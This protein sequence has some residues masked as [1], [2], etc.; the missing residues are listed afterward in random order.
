MALARGPRRLSKEA[1]YEQ[2]IALAMPVIAREGFGGFSLEEIA[3]QADVTRNNL[4]RYFP[5]GRPDIVAAV[6]KEAGRELTSGWVTDPELSLEQRLRANMALIADHA[7][8]PSDAWRIHRQARA[9]E[10]PEIAEIVN[11]Y[12]DTVVSNI[13]VNNI[14]TADPP[15]NARAAILATI[16]FGE[17]MIDAS[18]DAEIPR[19]QIGQV[20]LDVLVTALRSSQTSSASA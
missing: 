19:E 13:A 16:A 7:F 11:G 17:T 2:L 8:G 1:R 4:Y 18:R 9:V 15:P 6:V 12:L 20:I 3:E 14:G 10:E 5:R